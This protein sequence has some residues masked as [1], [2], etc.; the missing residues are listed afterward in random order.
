MKL[1]LPYLRDEIFSLYPTL[2]RHHLEYLSFSGVLFT[3][4]G[5]V[6]SSAEEGNENDQ[7]HLSYEEKAESCGCSDSR[8]LHTHTFVAFQDLKEATK[9]DGSRLF[10]RAWNSRTRGN[11]FKLKHSRYGLNKKKRFFFIMRVVKPCMGF[12]REVVGAL[13]FQDQVKR[14]SEKPGLLED[15]PAHCKWFG[16]D[17]L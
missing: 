13:S 12:S 4:H 8:R 5:P 1:L 3:R 15:I 2:M 11:V 10:T 7:K 16:L 14:D 17:D 9:K 6:G